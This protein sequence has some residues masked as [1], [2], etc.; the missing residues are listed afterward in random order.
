MVATGPYNHKQPKKIIILQPANQS[1]EP[2][3]EVD[4]STLPAAGIYV[5][6]RNKYVCTVYMR[7][8]HSLHMIILNKYYGITLY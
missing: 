4:I 6:F 2:L 1:S 8:V 7:T 3:T 5:D